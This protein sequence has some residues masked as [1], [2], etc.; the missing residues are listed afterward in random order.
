VQGANFD[1]SPASPEVLDRVRA[2]QDIASAGGYPLAA[3]A[4]QFPLHEPAV[5][6]VLSGTAKP[7]NLTRNLELLEIE[8]PVAE[9]EKYRPYTLVQDLG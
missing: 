7:A 5:A 4:F 2:M 9:Y 6:T 1:Y 3:A 8:V